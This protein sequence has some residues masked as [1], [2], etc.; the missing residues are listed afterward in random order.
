MAAHEASRLTHIAHDVIDGG[1]FEPTRVADVE[2]YS[3]L[4]VLCDA[5]G[6]AIEF[7]FKIFAVAFQLALDPGELFLVSLEDRTPLFS[8]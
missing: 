7:G 5:F 6:Q 8:Q 2:E 1:R 4:G 3:V